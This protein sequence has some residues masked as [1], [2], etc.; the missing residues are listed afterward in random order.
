MLRSSTINV[1]DLR[2]IS[3]SQ[4]ACSQDRAI[5]QP[6]YH[7]SDEGYKEKPLRSSIKGNGA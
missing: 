5:P 6:I 7:M 3:R 1:V 4:T 2:G